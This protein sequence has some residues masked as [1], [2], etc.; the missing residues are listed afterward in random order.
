MENLSGKKLKV[1]VIGLG[2]MGLLHSSIVN[3]LPNVKLVALCDK[4]YVIRRIAKRVFEGVQIIDNVDKMAGLDIDAVYIT[5][6]ISSHFPIA[7]NIFIKKI[8]SNLFIEKTLASTYNEAQE[9]CELS[10]KFG[11]VAMVGYMNRFAVTFRKAKDLLDKGSLGELIHFNAYA[12]SSDFLGI[13]T[14]SKSFARGGALRDIGCHTIDLALWFFGDLQ[15]VSFEPPNSAEIEVEKCF[16][17]KC[18]SGLEGEFGVSRSMKNYRM[19]KIGLVIEGSEGILKV[20]DERVDLKLNCGKSFSWYR[21]DLEDNVPFWLGA[22]EY[23]RE[24]E[25]FIKSIIEGHNPETSFQTASKVD[26]I[27]DEIDQR[28]GTR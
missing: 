28:S 1:A 15:V 21:H 16:K 17:V 4:S 26:L 5:T 20:D 23:F 10:R 13:N 14:K 27:I 11:N 24:D 3:V 8:A 2:K 7:R 18:L 19:P 22:S 25:H 12:Y 6:P 9:L